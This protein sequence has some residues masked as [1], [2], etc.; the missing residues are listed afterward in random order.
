MAFI[1]R[2]IERVWLI[3]LFLGEFSNGSDDI[4]SIFCSLHERKRKIIEILLFFDK[5]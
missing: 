5:L 2:F 1:Y 4:M 3:C